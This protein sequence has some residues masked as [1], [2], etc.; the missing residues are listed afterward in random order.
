MIENLK[1]DDF[2]RELDEMAK[3]VPPGSIV[4]CMATN[5]SAVYSH[6]GW[7]GTGI[8][9]ELKGL[10]EKFDGSVNG[11]YYMKVEKS[12][13]KFVE[14]TILYT[15]GLKSN[16]IGS[17]TRFLYKDAAK[18]GKELALFQS[19]DKE[20]KEILS[21]VVFVEG[22]EPQLMT[23]D[24]KTPSDLREGEYRAASL[25]FDLSLQKNDPVIVFYLRTNNNIS[26]S[27]KMSDIP[28]LLTQLTDSQK[29]EV[30]KWIGGKLGMECEYKKSWDEY[31]VYYYKLTRSKADGWLTSSSYG[32]FVSK[33]Q[34]EKYKELLEN[35]KMST[36]IREYNIEKAYEDIK[37]EAL[38]K[39]CNNNGISV[40]MKD[41]LT[42]TRGAAT[43]RDFGI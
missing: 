18:S 23:H 11:Y 2:N 16:Y 1:F 27:I 33:E 43:G 10:S 42:H 39:F 15:N 7:S 36:N 34:A 22:D 29:E 26:F 12:S 37:L 31:N 38:L 9:S 28:K 19:N 8:Q 41:V 20:I 24:G 14:G 40:K 25:N 32:P 30:A 4:R 21:K 5:D 13:S 35:E 6:R 17:K 3:E